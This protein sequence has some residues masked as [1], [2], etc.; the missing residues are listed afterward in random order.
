M[1]KSKSQPVEKHLKAAFTNASNRWPVDL[2]PQ[3]TADQ[4]AAAE[5]ANRKGT[6]VCAVHA[7]LLRPCGATLQQAADAATVLLGVTSPIHVNKV[8]TNLTRGLYV[9]VNETGK[10]LATM[11]K[12]GKVETVRLA[13]PAAAK[14]AAAKGKGKGKAAAKGK[15]VEPAADK[16]AD[17]TPAPSAS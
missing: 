10:R 12:L 17:A 1:N 7:M 5:R 6:A 15:A 11:P 4:L 16:A 8:R 2:G 14:P 3:P 9:A 13:L